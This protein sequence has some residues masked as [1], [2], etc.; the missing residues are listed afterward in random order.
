VG[1]TGL[2]GPVCA[3]RATILRPLPNEARPSRAKAN[4]LL[5]GVVATFKQLPRHA[6]D[7]NR[8][9]YNVARRN[10]EG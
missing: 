9:W 3:R 4:E 1:K 6:Q 8:D 7:L 10:L 5:Q 2:N